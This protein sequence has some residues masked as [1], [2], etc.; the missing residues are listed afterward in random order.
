MSDK[1]TETTGAQ[2][3][4]SA[5]ETSEKTRAERVQDIL[6]KVEN[7][8]AEGGEMKPS[9]TEYFKLLQ[10]AKEMTEEPKTHITVTW[11]EQRLIEK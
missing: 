5:N 4:S 6:L 10:L 8:L 9:L 2:K 3:T 7:K 1:K 11:I